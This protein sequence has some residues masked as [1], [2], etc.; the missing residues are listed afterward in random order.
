MPRVAINGAELNYELAG[1]GPAVVLV[2]EGVC[3]L[4]MWDEQAELT[5]ITPFGRGTVSTPSTLRGILT[6]SGVLLRESVRIVYG[7]T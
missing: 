1:D 6:T 5:V 4:R 7:C 3:D 2:H